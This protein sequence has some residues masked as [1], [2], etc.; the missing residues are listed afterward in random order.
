MASVVGIR[1]ARLSIFG[2]SIGRAFFPD[3]ANVPMGG[4]AKKGVALRKKVILNA[5]GKHWPAQVLNI[6][7]FLFSN[8]LAMLT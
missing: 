6:C 1:L 8:V 5:Y 3:K 2:Q 7:A 4:F